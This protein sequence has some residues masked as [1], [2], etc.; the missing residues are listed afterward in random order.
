MQIRI[1]KTKDCINATPSSKPNNGNKIN[2]GTK[3]TKN[4]IPVALIKVQANPAIT[5]SKV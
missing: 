2:N 4:K 5:F 3:C 1:L